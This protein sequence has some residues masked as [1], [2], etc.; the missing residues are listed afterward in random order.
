[1][2]KFKSSLVQK[3]NAFVKEF[4]SDTCSTDGSIL[5]C[6]YCEKNV[7][8]EKIFC[9]VQ[10]IRIAKHGTCLQKNK[11]G[12]SNQNNLLPNFVS[13]HSRKSEFSLD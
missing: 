5:Y 1:M 8:V 11:P 3:L 2:P 7:S 10:H 9:V 13:A 12:S 4:G 6:K